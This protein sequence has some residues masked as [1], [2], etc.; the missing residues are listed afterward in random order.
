MMAKYYRNCLLVIAAN[1]QK[2]ATQ[3]SNKGDVQALSNFD[4]HCKTLLSKKIEEGWASELEWWQNHAQLFPTLVHITLDILLSTSICRS[5]HTPF[6]GYKTDCNRPPSLFRSSN[7][8][9]TRYYKVCMGTQ[10]I[11]SLWNSEQV[12]E[13]NVFDFE[14]MLE[15]N[16]DC[17][18]WDK[19]MEPDYNFDLIENE[20]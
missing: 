6:L 16:I 8:Q 17:A 13:A 7:I 14:E 5:L 20:Y 18:E 19:E 10:T 15:N 4:K 2:I 11:Q 9:R 1:P 3:N 12:K